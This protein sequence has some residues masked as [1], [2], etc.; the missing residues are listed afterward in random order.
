[1]HLKDKRIYI[2]R[3]QSALGSDMTLQLMVDMWVAVVMVAV[4]MVAVVMVAVV[5]VAVVM[6]AVA[7]MVLVAVVLEGIEARTCSLRG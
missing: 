7:L 3:N 5:M 6:V 2:W 4:A 1:M